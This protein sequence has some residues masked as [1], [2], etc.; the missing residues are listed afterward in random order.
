[1]HRQLGIVHSRGPTNSFFLTA[2]SWLLG[3]TNVHNSAQAIVIDSP[4][5]F[6]LIGLN[7]KFR[8]SWDRVLNFKFRSSWDRVLNFKFRSSSDWFLPANFHIH[9]ITLLILFI[10]K[11][12]RKMFIRSASFDISCRQITTISKVLNESRNFLHGHQESQNITYKE[13]KWSY[14]FLSI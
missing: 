10:K 11:N 7:F 13:K 3:G 6:C 12:M 5:D 4:T 2:H 1:M 14:N 9:H 8:S